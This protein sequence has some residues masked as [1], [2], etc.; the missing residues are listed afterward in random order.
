MEIRR[1][2]A[3]PARNRAA[4]L[5]EYPVA[6]LGDEVA[7]LRHRDEFAGRHQPALRI[8]PAHQR[9]G[10]DDLPAVQV[11]LGLVVQFE[12]AVAD[13]GIETGFH[14]E[15]LVHGHDHPGGK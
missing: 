6:D 11:D 15:L 10:T 9:F 5:G 13:G 7:S 3:V 14:F 2:G 4:R 8:A 1:Q 12:F